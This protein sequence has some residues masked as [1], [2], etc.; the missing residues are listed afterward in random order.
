MK[1]ESKKLKLTKLTIANL[2]RTKGGRPKCPCDYLLTD[3]AYNRDYKTSW[4]YTLCN[5]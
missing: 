1:T 4:I 2:Q 3:G 5:C